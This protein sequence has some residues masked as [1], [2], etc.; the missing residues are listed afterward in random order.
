MTHPA[1]GGV[2]KWLHSTGRHVRKPRVADIFISYAREDVV[3]A[4]ALAEAFVALGW[5]VWW[6]DSI[7]AG[8][9]FDEVIDQQLDAASCVIVV[10]STASVGSSWVR[11]EASAAEEQGKLVPGSFEHDLR[12]P[13][14]F[15]QLRVGHLTSTDLWEPANDTLQL[16]A[17]IAVLTGKH[18][19]GVDQASLQPRI[20]Q[21]SSGANLV[22]VGNWRITL[23]F[24][25][26]RAIYDLTF[27][28]NS[29]VTGKAKWTISRANLAGRWLFDPAEQVLHLELSGGLQQGTRAIPV[30][31]IRWRTADVA[32]CKF[33]HRRARLERITPY[34]R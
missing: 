3:R 24:L 18:P 22:T 21:R 16:L 27:H 17:D 12:L 20:R 2:V 30:K 6:D 7:R 26:A 33:D 8:A 34:R 4:H 32:D 14:R 10:W 31:I 9:P 5:S 23:H 25:A 29:T 1:T 13:V 19:S 15:R 28:P 11:A